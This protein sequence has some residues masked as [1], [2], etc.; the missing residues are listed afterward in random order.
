MTRFISQTIAAFALAMLTL[1]GPANAQDNAA[2]AE[3]VKATY[4]D[5]EV[6]CLTAKPDQ[7]R[8]R[9]VG[10]TA[11]GQKALIVH[12][13]KLKDAKTQSGQKIPAAIRITTPLGSILR[14]GVKVRVDTHEPKTAA[15]EVCVPSGCIVS[16]AVSEEFLGELKAGAT[17]NMTFTV[18]QQGEVAVKVSLKG[19]TKAF[20]AL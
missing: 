2:P 9:Q 18:L 5:W 12:V 11:D 10:K 14:A 7:C 1:A 19:F 4:S 15:F 13:A 3:T 20:K 17:A 16:D 6:V 8:M